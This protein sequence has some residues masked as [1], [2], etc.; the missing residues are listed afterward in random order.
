MRAL[1]EIGKAFAE[2]YY[3]TFDSNR[4]NLQTLYQDS[5]ML[6]LENEQFAGMQAIMTKLTVR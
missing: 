5:S 4:V 6:T 3:T 2:H 1:T